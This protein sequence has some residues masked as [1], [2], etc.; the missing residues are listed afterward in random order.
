MGLVTSIQLGLTG[1]GSYSSGSP[2]MIVEQL[3]EL[4]ENMVHFSRL[5][6]VEPN[7]ASQVQST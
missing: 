3:W 2:H 1:V 6:S 5:R 7:C 4:Q